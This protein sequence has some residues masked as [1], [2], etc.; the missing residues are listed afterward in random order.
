[1]NKKNSINLTIKASDETL[2]SQLARHK[3]FHWEFMN[4]NLPE[5][6]SLYRLH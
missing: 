5:T 3:L 6:K 4:P 1:M 2:G